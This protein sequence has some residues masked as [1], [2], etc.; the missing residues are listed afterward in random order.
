MQQVES[1]STGSIPRIS[2]GVCALASFAVVVLTGLAAQNA[3]G[4]VLGKALVAMLL[5]YVIGSVIGMVLESVVR[6]HL[7]GY[8]ERHPVRE[9]AGVPAPDAEGAI[10][11]V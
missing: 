9:A 7:A 1:V 8:A 4:H 3:A 10:E 5:G 2:A 6:G 11:S